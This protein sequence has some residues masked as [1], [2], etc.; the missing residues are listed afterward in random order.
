MRVE[1]KFKKNVSTNKDQ[2]IESKKE[3]PEVRI[4]KLRNF[5]C[6]TSSHAITPAG[7]KVTDSKILKLISIVLS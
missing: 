4:V 3:K 2:N 7:I 6:I 5:Y 1:N